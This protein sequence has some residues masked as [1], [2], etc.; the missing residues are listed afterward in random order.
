MSST[1]KEDY[2]Q[3]LGIAKDASKDEIK[4]AYRKLAFKY[5][6][7]KNQGNKEAE[8]MFKKVAEAYE[9][10]SDDQ[11]RARYDQYGHAGVSGGAGGFGGFSGGAGFGVNLDEALRTFMDAFGGGN[12]GR[13]SGF[14]IFDDFFGGNHG[15]HSGVEGDDLR[16]DAEI[17]FEE[18]AFGTTK[19]VSYSALASCEECHG[20]GSRKGSSRVSCQTCHGT[21]QVARSQGFFSISQTCPTCSGY[22]QVVKDPCTKCQGKGRYK[23]KKKLS[24]KIPA[25]VE[26]GS[27]MRLNGEGG[28]GAMGGAA[29]SLYVFIHVKEHEIFVREDNDLFCEV[30]VEWSVV[31]NGGTVHVPTLEGSAQLKIPAGTQPNSMFRL[32]N[33]GVVGLKGS[34]RGD[35]MVKLIV[36]IPVNVPKE[37]SELVSQAEKQLN[38]THFP[39]CK[40]FQKK[41]EKMNKSKKNKWF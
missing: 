40:A 32:K 18:A 21:G 22:G 39:K 3:L 1:E 5:H 12:S 30:P 19:E 31:V 6:P 11:K 13:S 15:T 9:I 20:E 14:G 35:I 23:K 2:Y 36:E 7:D 33:Q 16:Y 34:S 17:S 26:N 8:V 24:I 28:A 10:L 41:L 38:E 4:K 25:G 29:G 27:R 37:V